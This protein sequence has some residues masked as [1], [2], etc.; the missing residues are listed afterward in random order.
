MELPLLHA[1]HVVFA[2]RYRPIICKEWGICAF[3]W[4]PCQPTQYMRKAAIFVDCHLVD[5]KSGTTG[6]VQFPHPLFCGNCGWGRRAF[7]QRKLF[8][9]FIGANSKIFGRSFHLHKQS[10]CWRN[11]HVLCLQ[12]SGHWNYKK[13]WWEWEFNSFQNGLT[14]LEHQITSFSVFADVVGKMSLFRHELNLSLR[15]GVH[16]WGRVS[17]QE[18][19]DICFVEVHEDSCSCHVFFSGSFEIQTE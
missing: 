1:E 4:N 6:H 9:V 15:Q 13:E 18:G 14:V 16:V 19:C 3:P 5:K 7:H 17:R 10:M 2:V 11:P 12:T 8:H